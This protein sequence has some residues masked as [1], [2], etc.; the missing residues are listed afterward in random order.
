[1]DGLWGLRSTIT[2]NMSASVSD[3]AEAYTTLNVVNEGGSRD[4][5]YDLINTRQAI[6]KSIAG[7]LEV[8]DAFTDSLSD[9]GEEVRGLP[10]SE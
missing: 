9:A 6:L 4:E 1:M 7:S 3:L 5:P 8:I 2:A 10:A